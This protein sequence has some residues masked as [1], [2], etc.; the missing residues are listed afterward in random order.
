MSLEQVDVLAIKKWRP[1][2]ENTLSFRMQL[3]IGEI[4][5]VRPRSR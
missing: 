5:L 2:Y 4:M 3:G 1:A